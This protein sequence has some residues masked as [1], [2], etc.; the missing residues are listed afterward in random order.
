MKQYFHALE[1]TMNRTG[2]IRKCGFVAGFATVCDSFTFTR[3]PVTSAAMG[4]AVGYIW[5]RMA[6]FAHTLLP[7]TRIPI[8]SMACIGCSACE[9][10]Q[11][12]V[13]NRK[14]RQKYLKD[15]KWRGGLKEFY[16]K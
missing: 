11:D 2:F 15:Q 3:N 5:G 9:I 16:V 7:Q 12:P 13:F 10:L 6:G 1:M 8:L 4:I 14:K